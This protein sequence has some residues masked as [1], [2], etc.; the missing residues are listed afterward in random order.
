MRTARHILNLVI[1][2]RSIPCFPARSPL[3]VSRRNLPTS[4][5]SNCVIASH[6]HPSALVRTLPSRHPGAH[7]SSS[8]VLEQY[9]KTFEPPY[10]SRPASSFLLVSFSKVTRHLLRPFA[11]TFVAESLPNNANDYRRL[12]RKVG[13]RVATTCATCTHP[14]RLRKIRVYKTGPQRMEASPAPR[15]TAAARG[16]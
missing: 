3:C 16:A 8:R 4:A 5:L 7:R 15:R 11:P 12:N 1:T 10:S 6:V 9:Q 2:I 13:F 14:P